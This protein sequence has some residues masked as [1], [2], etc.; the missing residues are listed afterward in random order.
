MPDGSRTEQFYRSGRN[1]ILGAKKFTLESYGMI[2]RADKGHSACKCSVTCGHPK[3]KAP[4]YGAGK[5]I[6]AFHVLGHN[7]I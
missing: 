1:I 2:C 3:R 7:Q 6:H 5:S 4:T